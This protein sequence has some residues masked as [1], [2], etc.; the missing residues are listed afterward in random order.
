VTFERLAV[1]LDQI[2]TLNLPT[3]PTKREGNRPRCRLESVEVDAIA[4]SMLRD[5]VEGAILDHLDANAMEPPASSLRGADLSSVG[6][7]SCEWLRIPHPFLLAMIET[8]WEDVEDRK[9]GA[10]D[11]HDCSRALATRNV[12]TVDRRDLAT[13][14]IRSSS[15]CM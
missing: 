1:T 6:V 8:D 4:P 12:V 2:E 11:T 5:M 9:L 7:G 13:K 15:N 3:S 14:W 10:V